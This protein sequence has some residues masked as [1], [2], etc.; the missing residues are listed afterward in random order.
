M[1]SLLTKTVLK[2][3][4]QNNSHRWRIIF[5]ISQAIYGCHSEKMGQKRPQTNHPTIFLI[6]LWKLH[7][8][9]VVGIWHFSNCHW[10]LAPSTVSPNFNSYLETYHA[11]PRKNIV[12]LCG[13]SDLIQLLFLTWVRKD[14]TIV[15]EKYINFSSLVTI[16]CKQTFIWSKRAALRKWFFGAFATF[17]SVH[18]IPIFG[19]TKSCPYLSEVSNYLKHYA[20][21]R[22]GSP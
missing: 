1:N 8:P 5:P 19:P 2:F 7:V 22:V 3:N 9:A 10:K 15:L 21:L 14:H 12:L 13:R 17:L 16:P 6:S 20:L 11:D 4:L 18:E